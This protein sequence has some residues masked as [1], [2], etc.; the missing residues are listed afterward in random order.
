MQ[1]PRFPRPVFLILLALLLACAPAAAKEKAPNFVQAMLDRVEIGK[2]IVGKMVILFPLV[3]KDEDAG[4]SVKSQFSGTAPA[5]GEPEFPDKRYDV[6]ADNNGKSPVLVLGGTVIVGGERDRL[7]RH[8]V[9]IPAGGGVMMRTLPA[10]STSE[11]RR[12]IV[13]FEMAKSLAPIYLRKE[14]NF[15]GS[16]T[17]VPMFISRNLEFRNEG[18]KRKSL[19]AIGTS[20]LLQS[21]TAEART[22]LEAAMK[23]VEN[24]GR[25]VG[26]IS[27]MRGRIQGLALYGSRELLQSSG[28]AYLV[29][30][31][32]SAAAVALQAEKKKIP[33]PGMEDPDKNLEN[34]TKEAHKL[35]GKL[36]KARLKND[37]AYP[38]GALGERVQI[39]LSDRTRGRAVG[40]DGKLIHLAVYPY[41]PF[42]SRLYGSAIKLPP[43]ATEGDDGDDGAVEDGPIMS[44]PNRMGLAELSRWAGRGHRVTHSEQR[45]LNGMGR[46]GVR[47]GGARGG[48]ARGGG[49]GGRRR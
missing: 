33:L 48:G 26:V 24:R 36:R 23:D 31:T 28:P 5:F 18:D 25:I 30:A 20:D 32:Y 1:Y 8:D 13:D 3:L 40:V 44:D 11:I 38:E 2:P 39:Q 22:K 49:G 16:S 10:A 35:L 7:L 42:E 17:S 37:K 4:L 43:P 6:V 27:S 34:V 45:L 41:D 14:A 9:V 47:G 29:G 19:E 15:G 12:E 46:G 21:W